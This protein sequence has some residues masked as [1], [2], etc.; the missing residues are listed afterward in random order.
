METR[1][2]GNIIIYALEISGGFVQIAFEGQQCGK[3]PVSKH[4]CD[5]IF[6]Q[7]GG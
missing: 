7:S 6:L 3:S 5:F 2:S 1:V 4:L